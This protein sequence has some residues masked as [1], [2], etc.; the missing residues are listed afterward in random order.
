MDFDEISPFLAL[1]VYIYNVCIF[2]YR[3]ITSKLRNHKLE[4][5]L[6]LI[7]SGIMA[8][9]VDIS[10]TLQISLYIIL[11]LMMLGLILSILKGDK[12]K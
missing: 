7:I 10:R 8:N 9:L 4:I 5:F 2:A 12:T 3:L 6:S 1:A 11:V